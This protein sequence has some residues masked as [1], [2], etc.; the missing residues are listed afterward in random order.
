MKIGLGPFFHHIFTITSVYR[1][2]VTVIDDNKLRFYLMCYILRIVCI[3]FMF[4]M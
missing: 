1:A 3:F 4:M 2:H